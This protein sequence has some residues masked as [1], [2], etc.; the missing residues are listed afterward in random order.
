VD[1][2]WAVLAF[3]PIDIF[4]RRIAGRSLDHLEHNHPIFL[5]LAKVTLIWC[6]AKTNG[7]I[8]CQAP[9]VDHELRT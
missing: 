6:P 2:D 4:L 5:P 9:D 7:V 8:L 3:S 1:F